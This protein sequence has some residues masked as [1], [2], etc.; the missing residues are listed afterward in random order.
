MIVY[1]LP[2]PD[3]DRLRLA[4]PP[5]VGGQGL[6]LA[7]T[8]LER[9]EGTAVDLH[10]VIG[11]FSKAVAEAVGLLYLA[12]SA[13]ARLS[14][15][16]CRDIGVEDP[17]PAMGGVS[18]FGRR[19]SPRFL[20]IQENSDGRPCGWGASDRLATAEQMA[21][22]QYGDHCCYP[23]ETPGPLR[24]L[25]LGP[26]QRFRPL[27]VECDRVFCG[28]AGAEGV[29]ARVKV[30]GRELLVAWCDEPGWAPWPTGVCDDVWEALTLCDEGDRWHAFDGSDPELET[31]L[32]HYL[33]KSAIRGSGAIESEPVFRYVAG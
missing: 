6:R 1:S 31:A 8:R 16:P 33:S 26:D 7:L 3:A 12:R 17:A 19:S 11:W 32:L 5:G 25:K 20:A 4:V 14:P 29:A 2:Q 22:R 23:G 10:L 9:G 24:T 13:D 15:G 18:A 21:S 27:W 30:D 28:G